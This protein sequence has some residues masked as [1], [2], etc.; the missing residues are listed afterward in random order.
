MLMDQN[1]NVD[2]QIVGYL[3]GVWQLTND[4]SG[5]SESIAKM[6]EGFEK[7]ERIDGGGIKHGRNEF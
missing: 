6:V 4:E 7:K 3:F 2:N 5:Y 1:Y